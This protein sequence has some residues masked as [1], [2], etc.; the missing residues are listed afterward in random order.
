MVKSMTGYGRGEAE[1]NGKK[2]TVEVKSVNHRFCEVNVKTSI[3]ALALDDIVRKEIKKRFS[4]GYFDAMISFAGEACSASSVSVNISLLEGYMATAEEISKKF[5]I[6]YPPSFGDLVS[7]KD[8]FAVSCENGNFDDYLPIIKTA[9]CEALDSLAEIRAVEGSAAMN[10]VKARFEKVANLVAEIADEN[11]KSAGV[12]LEKLQC[13]I[14]K[15]VDD[16][17]IDESRLAQEA[18]MLA[19]RG[20]VSEEIER[21]TSHLD[22]V[23]HLFETDE[24]IGRKLEFFLQEIN[25][26]TNTIGSKSQSSDG[27]VNVVEIK[28]EL[29]KIREQAQNIE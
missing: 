13:R 16:A 21:L 27:A 2:I 18:A 29:E 4:R 9:L 28:S 26:E 1:E 12:R 20:D 17:G 23:N 8:L 5:G 25:R 24:P 22:Q 15:I 6:E 10:D 19:D 11:E 7:V 14:K 3:R